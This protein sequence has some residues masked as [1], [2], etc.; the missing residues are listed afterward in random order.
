MILIVLAIVM[1]P[2]C[3][4]IG[5]LF[6]DAGPDTDGDSDSY[7]TQGEYSG[8]LEI[9]EQSDVA[10]L[11]GH[12]SIS[13]TLT[14][15]CYSCTDLNELICL[16][17][18]GESLQI[19]NNNSLTDLDGLNGI[20][21]VGWNLQ[22]NKNHA[23][24]NVNGLS[25]ITSV[26]ATLEILGN[27]NL[28]NLDGLGGITSVDGDLTIWETSLTNLDGLG[29]ITSVGGYLNVGTN[30]FP[31][32]AVCELLDQLTSGPFSINVGVNLNDSCTPV[33]ASCP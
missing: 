24:T 22:I 28:N 27:Y 6:E 8:D 9:T 26:G 7:C 2:A 32:C 5:S 20:T 15:S 33:P 14:I 17:S 16:T 12:T 1:A 18:V 11:A 4:H 30:D 21:S 29:G 10:A 3:Q 25:G 23:L 19:W 31:D 13:G